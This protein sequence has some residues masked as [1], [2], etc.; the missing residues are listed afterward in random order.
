MNEIY[1]APP[2]GEN[3]WIELYNPSDQP[4]SLDDYL[5]KDLT[6]KTMTF[7][8]STIQPHEFALATSSA[9]LN[10]KD[11]SVF[12]SKKSGEVVETVTYSTQFDN[13]KS[14]SKCPDATGT[15]QVTAVS[16]LQNNPCPSPTPALTPT[17]E[18]TAVPTVG[19]SPSPDGIIINEVLPAPD[20]GENEWIELYNTNT[21]DSTLTNW[22]I[23]TKQFSLILPAHGY[24]VI[25]MNT[26]VFNNG[27][28]E[29][30][31]LDSTKTKKDSFIYSSSEKN[32]S[33]GRINPDAHEFCFQSPSKGQPNNSCQTPT[34]TPDATSANSNT[35][36]PKPTPS[37]KKTPTKA[38]TSD[39]KSS[40]KSGIKTTTPNY[41]GVINRP[42]TSIQ[43]TSS[44]EQEY[45]IAGFKNTPRHIANLISHYGALASLGLSLLA[46]G[47]IAIKMKRYYY[48]KDALLA[49]VLVTDICLNVHYF[50]FIISPERFG[51]T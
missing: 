22:Y 32:T 29:I 13:N 14:Y 48:E 5:I 42:P 33:W 11:E 27:G 35:T 4:L 46:F 38:A 26:S 1:P 12:L 19:S 51:V 36:S 2:E 24:A 45:H 41:Q 20:S 23:D 8:G 47:L 9:L 18:I 50:S 21:I 25:E 7:N 31:L 40:S 37:P 15:W 49:L 10:N 3:E 17:P 34:P 44:P 28:D 6:G 30:N 39:T 16:K 43:Q